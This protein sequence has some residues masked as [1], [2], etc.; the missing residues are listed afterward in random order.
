MKWARQSP[1]GALAA[2]SSYRLLTVFEELQ[3]TADV[4][5]QLV[6]SHLRSLTGTLVAGATVSTVIQKSF[7]V[8]WGSLLFGGWALVS[9]LL[10]VGPHIVRVEE[11][12]LERI[13]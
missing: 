4:P 13:Q 5:H 8:I 7:D 2:F 10:L 11:W 1:R 9:L 3:E 12:L 6:G